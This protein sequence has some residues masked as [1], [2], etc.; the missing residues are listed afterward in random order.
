MG[1]KEEA[2]RLKDTTTLNNREIAERVGENYNTVRSYLLRH[3][4]GGLNCSVANRNNYNEASIIYE[5]VISCDKPVTIEYVMNLYNL[6]A[7]E[8]EVVSFKLN[9]Y[10]A[11]GK[12]NT[13]QLKQVKL[14]V[15][16][17]KVQEVTTE[18][19]DEFLKN[20]DFCKTCERPAIKYNDKGQTLIIDVADLHIGL[21]AWRNET[22]S[23]YDLNICTETFLNALQEIIERSKGRMFKD[24]YI[25]TLGDLL[26]VDND[27]NTTTKGTPQQADG[28]ISKI[29]DL[30]FNLMNTAIHWCRPLGA[31]IHYI[32]TCGNHDRN[33]GYYLAKCLEKANKDVDFNILPNPQKAIVVGNT[34]IGFMHG[35]IGNAKNKT[36]WLIT[37]YRKEYGATK[38]AEIHAGHI[39][40]EEVKAYNNITV[41]SVKA[42]TGASYWEH[43]QGYRSTRGLQ[44]FIYDDERGLTETWNINA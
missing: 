13:K 31:R 42:L 33:T 44:C 12:E 35:D 7:S 19:I 16:P 40:T 37:D 14:V 23:D 36:T 17:K 43:Q 21:L 38:W 22:G 34:L 11:Q 29:F 26:H 18:F 30:A 27:T 9:N 1:W 32:Y 20:K 5:D 10:E 28:R 39:H 24:V 41:R 25:V 6:S 3:S 8:W 2:L 15:K 4:G